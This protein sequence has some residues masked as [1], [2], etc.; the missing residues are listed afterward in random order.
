M[1][2]RHGATKLQP[3]KAE[4]KA[5]QRMFHRRKS[6]LPVVIVDSAGDVIAGSSIDLSL[7]GVRFESSGPLTPGTEGI[8]YLELRAGAKT[9]TN[10]RVLWSETIDGAHQHGVRFSEFDNDGRLAL[11]DAIY[12]PINDGNLEAHFDVADLA[13]D[14]QTARVPK[15]LSEPHHTYYMRLIRR[16]E[17]V[18]KVGPADVDR[19]LFAVLH[20]RYDFAGSLLSLNLTTFDK[21]DEYL[22][23]I[24]G[25]PFVN[26]SAIKPSLGAA[27]LIPESFALSQNIVPIKHV[28]GSYVVA[29]ADPLDLPALDIIQL[30]SKGRFDLRF[31]MIGDV[32]K[33]IKSVYQAASLN[34]ADRLI[35]R[36]S[37]SPERS[38]EIV[39][40]AP[41]V[42]DLETLR[43]LSDATPIISL[44]DSL[45]RSA[46]EERASD[47]HVEP[48]EDAIVVRFRLD[49]ILHEM[50]TLPRNLISPVVSRIKVM[51][52]MDITERL[53]PQDGRISMRYGGKDFELR[54]SSLPTV[55]GE[56]IVVRLL[57]KDPTFKTMRSIGFSERNYQLFAPLIRRPY[58]MILFCG[59]TGSGKSTTLFS[60]IQEIHDGTTNIVTVEDP[61]EYRVRGI[62]HVELVPKRGVTFPTV[63]RSILRSDPDVIYVGEI[64]DRETADLSI[65][66]ALT[67]HLL[68]STLHTNTAVQAISRL[69]DIGVDGTLIGASL[70]GVVGQR[71]LRKNCDWCKESY[72]LTQSETGVIKEMLG[73]DVPPK[74]L[75]RGRGCAHCHKTGFYGRLAVHEVVVIDDELRTLI[76]TSGTNAGILK[77]YVAKT[78]FQDL[79]VDAVDRML[80]GETTLQEVIRVTV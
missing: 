41:D 20:Q 33:A 14:K 4:S 27:E 60:C 39:T 30:R 72:A 22:G 2:P 38:I 64:R 13:I 43:R 26:L 66:A 74:Q 51:A 29:M 24:Y 31:A 75:Q 15:P 1:T 52:G 50:R 78:D 59:P 37:A 11:I 9:Q 40:S 45:M 44:V 32:E 55:F 77:E 65:R 36:A 71:L 46:V 8:A 69:V 76:G 12:A 67:G 28:D 49:G 18:A 57:E 25:I 80:K 48:M 16:L 47:I 68:F 21:L 17:R 42:T 19:L 63:L 35:D 79:R 56:K 10:A 73:V 62:N 23:A 58:G 54:V 53:I 70:I 5:N 6:A 7:D 61:V 3:E 34:A